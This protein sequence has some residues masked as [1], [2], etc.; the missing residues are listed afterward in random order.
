MSERSASITFEQAEEQSWAE[1][2]AH[3]GTTDWREFQLLVADLLKAMGYHPHWVAPPGKDGGVDIIAYP[4]PLGT[5]RPRIKVQVKRQKEKTNRE[6]LSAFLA[7][8]GD[9]DIGLFINTG[10]FTRDAE[11]FARS[12]ERRQ[13][14]LIDLERLVDLWIEHYPKLDDLAR[15]RL[16]LSPIYF[17][18]PRQGRV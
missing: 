15:D 16:P 7:Q 9:Q 10:G 17:V 4:D 5:K 11:E 2:E 3:V 13:I 14:T 18:R 8:L 12:Q 1:L 6:V